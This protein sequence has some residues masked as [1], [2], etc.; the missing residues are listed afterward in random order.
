MVRNVAAFTD[1]YLPTVNGV[2]Y[3][4]SLWRSRWNDRF[5][6]LS[7][8]YPHSST[9]EPRSD[10]FPVPSVQA[11]IYRQYRLGLPVVPTD[12][13]TP[14]IVHVHSPF[15]LG[16]AGLRFGTRADVPV[17]ATYHTILADRIEQRVPDIVPV[18][19]L[20]DGCLAYERQFY[21]AVDLI[22]AP[23]AVARRE[24]RERI[25]PE[26]PIEI[27]PNGIDTT[28]FRP[29]DPSSF[30]D[31]YD[32]DDSAPIV[33]YTGRHS[34]EKYLSELID[35]AAETDLTVVIAGDGPSRP[36]LE[37]QAD[38]LECDVTFLGFLD[39]EELPAFYS[40]LD[41]FVFPGRL[42]T[43][44]LVALEANACGTP[45]VA[46]AAGAL[47]RTVLD[48]E[49]GYHY[50]PGETVALREAIDRTLAERK[51]LR[52]L[53]LRRREMISVTHSLAQLQT[54]Y[55]ELASA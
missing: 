52:D 24:I 50:P 46:A 49:T 18:S 36:A 38:A 32:I 21:D 35:A 7:V 1:T 47:T 54:L 12:L 13:P 10:E 45:V 37:A 41:V 20:E 15:T 44:G 3:T 19:R 5:G 53:C 28:T 42:E 34:P 2:T 26:T 40:A 4:I 31:T 14:D 25:R 22:T 51:R 39:R 16:L 17:V 43:Q 55:D 48:G 29:V 33:G 11:P 30:I 8:V 23:T 9:Y 27:V 6:R